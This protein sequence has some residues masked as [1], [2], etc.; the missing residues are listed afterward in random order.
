MFYFT[1]LVFFIFG[2]MSRVYYKLINI[3]EDLFYLLILKLALRNISIPTARKNKE[4]KRIMR[5][6]FELYEIGREVNLLNY[7]LPRLLATFYGLHN[8]YVC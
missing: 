8:V 5:L 7:L 2:N 1:A 6:H 4:L 3:E